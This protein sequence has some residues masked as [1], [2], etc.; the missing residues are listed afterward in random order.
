MSSNKNCGLKNKKS[1]K[2]DE[3][4]SQNSQVQK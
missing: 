3:V 2:F 4:K 1:V